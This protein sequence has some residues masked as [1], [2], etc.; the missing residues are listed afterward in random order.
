V[1]HVGLVGLALVAVALFVGSL[2]YVFGTYALLVA[3]GAP[4]AN[5]VR[6]ALVELLATMLLLP[7]WPLWWLLGSTYE[8]R[9]GSGRPII[10]LHGLGMNR[11]NWLWLGGRLSAAGLGPLYGTTYFSPQ[12]IERSAQ[13]LQ[14]FVAGVLA[15]EG[16]EDGR[17]DIVAHS[18]GGVVARYFIEKLGG[19][20]QVGR[21][22]TIGSPHRG[23]LLGRMGLVPGARQLA[24][25][26]SFYDHIADY[27]TEVAYTSVWSRADALVAPP[28]SASI[29]PVGRDFVFTDLG[30]LSMLVSPR[31]LAV[32]QERLH[33]SGSSS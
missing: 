21:L 8:R 24:H 2:A 28:E 32:V 9:S 31:V 15:R 14:A 3:R 26:S 4:Q 11:T 25:G 27:S 13:K 7:L 12:T 22:I 17:V 10:L 18:M 5:W 33:D 6:A 16:P 29:E 30:H 19:S 1:A 23:T 20:A